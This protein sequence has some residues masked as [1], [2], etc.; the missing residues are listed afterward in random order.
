MSSVI[1]NHSHR[2]LA[3]SVQ[4]KG[5][6]G[7]V[8]VPPGGQIVAPQR[9]ALTLMATVSTQVPPECLTLD[10]AEDTARDEWDLSHA[11]LVLV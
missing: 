11:G 5:F 6:R 1:S 9:L 7:H 4:W 2:F 10:L 3:T 8:L